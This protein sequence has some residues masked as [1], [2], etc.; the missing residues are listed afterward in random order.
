MLVARAMQVAVVI[1]WLPSVAA[2]GVVMIGDTNAV[3]LRFLLGSCG[4]LL[5]GWHCSLVIKS[6]QFTRY[7]LNHRK[8]TT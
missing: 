3:S 6:C 2:P 8:Y 1:L 7:R 4:L 5:F